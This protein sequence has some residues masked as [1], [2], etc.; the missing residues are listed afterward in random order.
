[1]ETTNTFIEAR[2]RK[3]NER[4]GGNYIIQGAKKAC[5]VGVGGGQ[6]KKGGTS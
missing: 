4:G 2:N 6:K 3:S 1:M 5:R